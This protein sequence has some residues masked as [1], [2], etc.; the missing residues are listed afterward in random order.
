[1]H[2]I[3]DILTYSNFFTVGQSMVVSGSLNYR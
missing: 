1:M 3:C 2:W